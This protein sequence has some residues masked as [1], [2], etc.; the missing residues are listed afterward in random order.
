MAIQFPGSLKFSRQGINQDGKGQIGESQANL[1]MIDYLKNSKLEYYD[2]DPLKNPNAQGS[3]FAFLVKN[4]EDSEWEVVIGDN[5]DYSQISSSDY[6]NLMDRKEEWLSKLFSDPQWMETPDLIMS[7]FTPEIQQLGLSENAL[8]EMSMS[9]KQTAMTQ[10]KIAE[11]IEQGRVNIVASSSDAGLNPTQID[12]LTQTGCQYIHIQDED[13][14]PSFDKNIVDQDQGNNE[15]QDNNFGTTESSFEENPETSE[16]S[17]D[18]SDSEEELLFND[19]SEEL[20]IKDMEG[21][22]ETEKSDSFTNTEKE[23]FNDPVID[24]D[25]LQQNLSSSQESTTDAHLINTNTDSIEKFNTPIEPMPETT[26]DPP[27]M[28][29]NQ[30]F[31]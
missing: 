31:G 20:P 1:A 29:D 9:E 11:L 4:P 6:Q 13:I 10:Y 22:Y 24:D 27:Q 28:I 23:N 18:F 8:T 7:G 26:V 16:T 3:D 2:L 15:L 21:E 25:N 12:Q 5:K 14:G 30:N 19:N 17:L